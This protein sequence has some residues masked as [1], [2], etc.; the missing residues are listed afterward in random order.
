M[1]ETVYRSCDELR[2]RITNVRTAG[3]DAERRH[4][5]VA[6][7]LDG[8]PHQ[9][10]LRGRNRDLC[11]GFGADTDAGIAA[12]VLLDGHATPVDSSSASPA[13]CCDHES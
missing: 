3:F 8:K 6:F 11:L 2:S 13:A 12:R 7:D 5:L 10:V 4:E 1:I 9:G